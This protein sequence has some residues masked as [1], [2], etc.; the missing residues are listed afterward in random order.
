MNAHEDDRPSLRAS[1]LLHGKA[2]AKGRCVFFLLS[3]LCAS[4]SAFGSPPLASQP[5]SAWHDATAPDKTA[6]I[7]DVAHRLETNAGV[8]GQVVI[9]TAAIIRCVDDNHAPD[10]IQAHGRAVPIT[11]ELAVLLC[12]KLRAP[13]LGTARYE[14]QQQ[15]P[16]P[17]P[18]Q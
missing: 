10:Q 9:P 8:T 18:R 13:A 17:Q 11:T 2:G 7:G 5:L 3:A 4:A 1:R 12:I 16:R 14:V 15:L 6:L